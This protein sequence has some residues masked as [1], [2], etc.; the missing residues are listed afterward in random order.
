MTIEIIILPEKGDIFVRTIYFI[1]QNLIYG[2][3]SLITMRELDPL[4]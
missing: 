1:F 3:V 2:M 4:A